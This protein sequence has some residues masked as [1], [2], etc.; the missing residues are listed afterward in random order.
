MPATSTEL[1]TAPQNVTPSDTILT[2]DENNKINHH[3]HPSHR[4][5]NAGLVLEK[6][7]YRYVRN[8]KKYVQKSV[9]PDSNSLENNSLLKNIHKFN[10][11]I[12]L[13]QRVGNH[14]GYHFG[15]TAKSPKNLLTT[16]KILM[17]QIP[18]E[19]PASYDSLYSGS[20]F[21]GLQS[22]YLKNYNVSVDL[23]YVDFSR[24][25]LN[26]YFT[27]EGLTEPDS[28]LTTFF[29][30]DIIGLEGNTFITQKWGVDLQTDLIHWSLFEEFKDYKDLFLKKNAEY[31]FL[32]NDVVFMRWK[33]LFLVPDHK[34]NQIPGASFAGF[35]YMC[36][37]PKN[38]SIVG[39][40][41]HQ[42]S[43][44]FQRILLN[45]TSKNSFISKEGYSSPHLA[46]SNQQTSLKDSNETRINRSY[47]GMMNKY[48]RESIRVTKDPIQELERET[49]NLNINPKI[50]NFSIFDFIVANYSLANKKPPILGPSPIYKAKADVFLKSQ[51]GTSAP[52]PLD[53]D[54]NGDNVTIGASPEKMVDAKAFCVGGNFISFAQKKVVKSYTIENG[55]IAG[56][57]KIYDVFKENEASKALAEDTKRGIT[58]I[59]TLQ[60]SQY[61]N[62]QGRYVTIGCISGKMWLVDVT[63]VGKTYEFGENYASAGP[64]VRMISGNVGE[65]WSFRAS[66]RVDLWKF[67][68]REN[69]DAGKIINNVVVSPFQKPVD[70][71][72]SVY[73]GNSLIQK[74]SSSHKLKLEIVNSTEIWASVREY[75]YVYD[76]KKGNFEKNHRQIQEAELKYTLDLG[77]SGCE[78]LC[79]QVG[80]TVGNSDGRDNILW[81]GL[82]NGTIVGWSTVTKR[83]MYAIDVS[84]KLLRKEKESVA[85][86][87]L[88]SVSCSA[89]WVGMS[90]GYIL[91]LD[92]SKIDKGICNV[93]KK[94]NTDQSPVT[95]IIVDR[96]SLLTT[97]KCIQVI[98]IHEN[99]SVHFWDGML[100]YDW[101]YNRLMQ[102][103]GNYC[104]YNDWTVRILSWNVGATKPS[105][106]YTSSR[107]EDRLFFKNWLTGSSNVGYSKGGKYKHFYDAPDMLVVNLQ[108]VIDLE[109]KRANAKAFWKTATRSKTI[110]QINVSNRSKQ[111]VS[112]LMSVLETVFP[113]KK[114][115]LFDSQ[116]L[117]GLFTCIFVQSIH[118]PRLH[119]MSVSKAKTGLGGLHGNKG[120]ISTRVIVDDTA[121]CFI[122]AHL[123]AGE[124]LGSTQSR[125]SNCSLIL[126]SLSY[127][128]APSEYQKVSQL[129]VNSP[130]WANKL[131]S[132]LGNVT[133]DAFLDGGD[134]SSML[135]YPGCVFGGDLNYRL[136]RINQI[137]AI[138]MIQQGKLDQLLL[139]DQLSQQL[140]CHIK[141]IPIS[142]TFNLPISETNVHPSSSYSSTSNPSSFVTDSAMFLRDKNQ[143]VPFALSSFSEAIVSFPPT[144]K[145]DVGTNDYDTSEKR[146][147]PA[148]CDRILFRSKRIPTKK[149]SGSQSYNSSLKNSQLHEKNMTPPKT[150][151]LEYGTIDTDIDTDD[152]DL[153]GPTYPTSYLSYNCQMS[154][155]RPISCD[156][157]FSVKNILR[158]ARQEE[159]D[160]TARRWVSTQ[161]SRHLSQAK[162]DWLARLLPSLDKD[163]A[164]NLLVETGGHIADASNIILSRMKTKH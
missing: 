123:S 20:T 94:W 156:I 22:N 131:F 112:E 61:P 34:I 48:R 100:A 37:N 117:V 76:T 155:H 164:R 119:S 62:D 145:F 73:L 71:T 27:I 68:L 19:I 162:V 7:L 28:L 16:E 129:P 67:G 113:D 86:T 157:V 104:V 87:A 126:K 32:D 124:S 138:D 1:L 43:E 134:G 64:I 52:E 149:L 35:Y 88:G 95:D 125:N 55:D 153:Q 114:F 9:H 132:E 33:E 93:I 79:I 118:L 13:N 14:H 23:K 127:P 57:H 18:R 89:L 83:K 65:I 74:I 8:G 21:S 106:I 82:D 72:I 46:N 99:D 111:W 78:I 41:F 85:I 116:D 15:T 49:S 158:E 109:S 11:G 69:I 97:R 12:G 115:V 141:P 66:G 130:N 154:D 17:Y 10:I 75:V 77:F 120:A 148:W 108:E 40:Y 102:Q 53:D 45:H 159:M 160:L 36:Y 137:R 54:F 121:F 135:D 29:E 38:P 59:A 44:K 161:H 144:Y 31:N 110:S 122:N 42:D 142:Q 63:T 70:P 105:E 60:L 146:R 128:T 4:F 51:P 140:D 50:E 101:V 150:F 24:G 47:P 58:S 143:N 39:Y 139:N 107:L 84:K 163:E 103:T 133:L 5:E 98:S 151:P 136:D 3:P 96:W 6:C 26:G 56:I 30:A 2:E 92:I 147:V 90:S 81:A 80:S 152:Y 91:V 25:I